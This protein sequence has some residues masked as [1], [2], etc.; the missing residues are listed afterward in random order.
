[1]RSYGAEELTDMYIYIML[2]N[3]VLAAIVLKIRD[4]NVNKT[5]S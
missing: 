5:V 4:P 2:Y 1:M 3:V